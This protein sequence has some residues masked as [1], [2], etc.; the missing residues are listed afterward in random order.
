MRLP[1]AKALALAVAVMA[2]APAV[3]ARDLLM[4]HITKKVGSEVARC[5]KAPPDV[6]PPYPTVILLLN[7]RRDGTLNGAPQI[8]SPLDDDK[9]TKTALAAVSAASR[10]VRLDD[11]FNYKQDYLHW[12]SVR[13]LIDPDRKRF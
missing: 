11:F 5:F 1:V 9:M 3:A 8:V 2:I 10:C 6:N 4:E 7:F 12:R 13:V